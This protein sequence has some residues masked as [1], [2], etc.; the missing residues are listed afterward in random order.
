MKYD[1][2]QSTKVTDKYMTAYFYIFRIKAIHFASKTPW[3][4]AVEGRLRNFISQRLVTLPLRAKAASLWFPFHSSL[5]ADGAPVKEIKCKVSMNRS[6]NEHSKSIDK[7]IQ[8]SKKT[9]SCGLS[10]GSESP[11]NTMWL[12]DSLISYLKLLTHI[13]GNLRFPSVLVL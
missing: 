2:P 10:A 5:S 13:K 3:D 4:L 9:R 12:C 7:I 1:I 11:K 6:W 8:Y